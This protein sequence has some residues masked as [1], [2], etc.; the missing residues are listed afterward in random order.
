M[1]TYQIKVLRKKF[2]RKKK[3]MR[4]KVPEKKI[5]ACVLVEFVHEQVFKN[6]R[7]NR[8]GESGADI[9]NH[10]Q[11]CSNKSAMKTFSGPF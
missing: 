3:I 5:Q 9:Y 11:D 8:S 7:K 4:K 6:T 1:G 10:L 2:K